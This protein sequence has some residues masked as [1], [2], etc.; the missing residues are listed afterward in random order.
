MVFPKTGRFPR[1]EVAYGA[2][3]KSK[4]SERDWREQVRS[5]H[6]TY[7]EGRRGG[8][9]NAGFRGIKSV[10]L[11]VADRAG[12]MIMSHRLVNL[13]SDNAQ[14]CGE[15]HGGATGRASCDLPRS[16]MMTGRSEAATWHAAMPSRP[17]RR[18]QRS[19]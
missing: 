7:G 5:D 10:H 12:G 11:Q 4:V 15:A 6:G 9:R 16:S 3:I 17:S 13:T 14:V 8:P 19:H 18:S 2:V 1:R